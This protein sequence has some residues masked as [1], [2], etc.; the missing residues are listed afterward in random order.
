M[1]K[2]NSK[3]TLDIIAGQTKRNATQA[4]LQTHPNSSVQAAQAKVSQLLAK[5]EAQLYL[6]QHVEKAKAT[7]VELLDSEKDDIRLRASTDILDRTHGKAIQQIQ[8]STV[9][10]TLN[11]DLTSSL[12][13]E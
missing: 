6:N 3:K 5:P 4:Y 13:I 7:I 8:Q 2:A 1:L 9:G 12:G 11:I 10:I